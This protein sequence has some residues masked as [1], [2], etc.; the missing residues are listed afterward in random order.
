MKN[1]CIFCASGVGK[2]PIYGNSAFELGA[3]L[4][5]MNIGVVYGG[6]KIGIMGKLADGVLSKNGKIIGIIPDFL[7]KKEIAHENLTKLITVSSMHERK[8][9]MQDES[10]GFIA[11]PG[12][13]GTME[14]LFE[15]LT[16]GQLGL[17]R[18]PIGI[19]N[20]NGYYDTLI[21]LTERMVE[22]GLLKGDFK[23]M[24]LVS[25]SADELI[26]RMKSYSLAFVP[27]LDAHKIMLPVMARQQYSN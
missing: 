20:I 13:F 24:M 14:E 21:Q 11:L 1:I 15:I 18:K 4:A 16:W 26:Q 19:L 17:H 8:A 2:N 3:K 9:L 6:A 10:D 22:E 5:E 23:K 25:D 27:A 12:G 7:K